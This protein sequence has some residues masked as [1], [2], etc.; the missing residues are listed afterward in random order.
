[1][2]ALHR[3]TGWEL[4]FACMIMGGAREMTGIWWG[5]TTRRRSAWRAWHGRRL[6]FCD[7]MTLLLRHGIRVMRRHCTWIIRYERRDDFE[8]AKNARY[9]ENSPGS[10]IHGE[11]LPARGAGSVGGD[12]GARS[13]H[14]GD[15]G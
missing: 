1:M 12:A 11:G 3:R 15:L 8:P 13:Q 7:C 2:L 10:A 9:G 4:K 6:I 5:D 14:G